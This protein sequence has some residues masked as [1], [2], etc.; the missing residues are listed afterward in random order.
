M[1]MKKNVLSYWFT[2]VHASYKGAVM[3]FCFSILVETFPFLGNH[4]RR[5]FSI[6]LMKSLYHDPNY[7]RKKNKILFL[8]RVF[9]Q[10]CFIII[11]L[12]TIYVLKKKKWEKKQYRN[13]SLADK[14]QTP[15]HDVFDRK[16]TGLVTCG[17]IGKRKK[18]SSSADVISSLISK[19]YVNKHSKKSNKWKD[20]I[21]KSLFGFT[22]NSIE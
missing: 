8:H 17:F 6:A 13:S 9:V 14:V 4:F 22:P 3:Q 15:P 2:E 20:N 5:I 21:I 10:F 18:K 12:L 16:S 7:C 19:I 1:M 11:N